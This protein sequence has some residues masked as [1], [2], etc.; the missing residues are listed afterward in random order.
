MLLHHALILGIP[1]TRGA[2]GVRR[3]AARAARR[4][5][6]PRAVRVN[7]PGA[8]PAHPGSGAL[9]RPTRAGQPSRAVRTALRPYA[10]PRRARGS[11]DAGADRRARFSA[12]PCN[13]SNGLRSPRNDK[14]RRAEARIRPVDRGGMY[15]ASQH[16][17]ERSS[18]PARPRR[19]SSN[20]RRR[21]G[22]RQGSS[23]APEHT[24]VAR[25]VD[26]APRQPTAERCTP[27]SRKHQKTPPSAER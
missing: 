4:A 24:V 17:S 21:S 9:G 5:R 15:G 2:V 26:P 19:S 16:G 11:V 12:N 6:R 25:Q 10:H 14:R 20:F 8:A 1:P 7:L 18:R 22:Q 23:C 27:R 13:G 3:S